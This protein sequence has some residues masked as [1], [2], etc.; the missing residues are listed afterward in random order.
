M[1]EPQVSLIDADWMI[2]T[3]TKLL[4]KTDFV[5]SRQR[6]KYT[7]A[8]VSEILWRKNKFDRQITVTS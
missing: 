4:A 8:K 1:V 5:A 7:D 6:L 3:N 2:H